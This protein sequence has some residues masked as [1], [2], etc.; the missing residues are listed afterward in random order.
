[1]LQKK[2]HEAFQVQL[3]VISAVCLVNW[4]KY[5]DVII[6][7]GVTQSDIIHHIQ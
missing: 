7:Q 1:M 5:S 6:L 3:N 4:S 2:L